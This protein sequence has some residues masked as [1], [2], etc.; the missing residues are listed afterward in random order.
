[1]ETTLSGKKI[2][3]TTDGYLIDFSQW[4]KE[5]GKEIAKT[6]GIEMTPRHWE[7][8][9]WLQEKANAGEALSIREIKK[10]GKLDIKEFYALFPGGP[11]KISTKIAGVPKPKSCI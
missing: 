6:E 11:L 1:M 3:V 7:V 2:E 10:S 8:V 4:S 5:I 9:T